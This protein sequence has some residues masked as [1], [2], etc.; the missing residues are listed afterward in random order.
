MCMHNLKLHSY[1][2]GKC[3]EY[4]ASQRSYVH[5]LLPPLGCNSPISGLGLMFYMFRDM[6][7]FM[8]RGCQP[9]TQSPTWRTSPPY[10]WLPETRWPSYT[11]RH[12]VARDLWSARS[13][14]HNNWA[15]SVHII[16]VKHLHSRHNKPLS[17]LHC[18]CFQ[19]AINS[20]CAAT[21]IQ[22]LYKDLHYSFASFSS[23]QLDSFHLARRPP[24][25]FLNSSKPSCQ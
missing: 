10:L 14:T 7:C 15:A 5:I 9:F 8:E 13:R 4:A 23:P 2:L 1:I 21:R 19:H 24:Y 20:S 12:W 3:Q 18:G 11:T 17:T 25:S 16:P 6:W 22:T